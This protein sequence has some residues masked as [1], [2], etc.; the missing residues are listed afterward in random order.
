MK[1]TCTASCRQL[2]LDLQWQLH[3]LQTSE[4][5]FEFKIKVPEIGYRSIVS[6]VTSPTDAQ[7]H[8][9]DEQLQHILHCI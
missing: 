7:L 1:V 8:T 3:S 5:L 6:A 2:G 9:F 4:I